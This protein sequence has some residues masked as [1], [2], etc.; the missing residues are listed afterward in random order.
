MTFDKGKIRRRLVWLV[1]ALIFAIP[2]LTV[3]YRWLPVPATP[4]MMVRFV[5]G[6]GWHQVWTPLEK[7][8]LTARYAALA[9]EDNNFCIHGGVDWDAVGKVIDDWQDGGK[10]RGASTISMQVARNLFLWPGQD[11]VRKALEIPVTYLVEA[12]L[13]KKRILEIYLN[14]AEWGP[15]RYGLTSAANYHYAKKVKNLSGAEIYR[16]MA[17]LPSPRHWNPKKLPARVAWRTAQ[18][19][20]RVEQLRGTAFCV[21]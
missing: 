21:R 5:Q 17:I 2:V 14:I 10:L 11:P 15:G 4:L 12:I 7:M 9:S 19:P 16:L 1:L 3:A 8:P 20:Y 18:L 6:Y 13:P